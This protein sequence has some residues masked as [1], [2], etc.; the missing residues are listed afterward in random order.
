MDELLTLTDTM[1]QSQQI[2]H[3]LSA[4]L[5]TLTGDGSLIPEEI[6][7]CL[8]QSLQNY[9]TSSG[10]ARILAAR[11][12]IPWPNTLPLL[13]ESARAELLLEE[14][15][16]LVVRSEELRPLLEE[17][18]EQL[19]NT[20]RL[21]P[22]ERT[23][24]LGI[25]A[26][27]IRFIRSGDPE[28]EKAAYDRLESA[29]GRNFARSL[30]HL[31]FFLADKGEGNAP[32]R[33]GTNSLFPH[34]SSYIEDLTVHFQDVSP[35]ILSSRNTLQF[36]SHLDKIRGFARV[37]FF[38]GAEKIISRENVN[39]GSFDPDK[40]IFFMLKNGYLMELSIASSLFSGSFYALTSK[41]WEFLQDRSVTG[42]IQ[43]S[44]AEFYIPRQA[45]SSVSNLTGASV[46]K[47]MAIRDYC[48]HVD[49]NRKYLIE[50][51]TDTLPLFATIQMNGHE[52]EVCA[53]F[54]EK[55]MEAKGLSKIRNLVDRRRTTLVIIVRSRGDIRTLSEALPRN[56]SGIYFYLF[57][58]QGELYH[59]D[60]SC[61]PG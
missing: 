5:N 12:G 1:A 42:K 27:V 8:T 43:K 56:E 20:M 35:V 38:A 60:G 32:A 61:I 4:Q 52:V 34:Y 18:K 46:L 9:L 41:A 45:R 28:L 40:V 2:I 15:D 54:L 49:A 47:I 16:R 30:D 31:D 21:L 48:M 24:R 58:G 17:I 13:Q 37:Y 51:E 23:H 26:E 29:F 25:Y 57:G 44:Y 19:Q 11:Y 59:S 36:M 10:K 22:E 50:M 53:G 6:I 39:P 7:T 3:D 55:G 33:R 14:Y